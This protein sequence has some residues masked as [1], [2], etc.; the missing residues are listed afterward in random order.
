MYACKLVQQYL[1]LQ[2]VDRPN[3]LPIREF[4]LDDIDLAILKKLCEVKKV[5]GKEY[6]SFTAAETFLRKTFKK[7]E[8]I[9]IFPAQFKV[10]LHF[11]RN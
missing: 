10:H 9:R 11:T 6:Q 2:A 8:Q 7:K 3:S 4:H 5:F 1:L